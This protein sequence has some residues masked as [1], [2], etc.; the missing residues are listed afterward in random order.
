MVPQGS[1]GSLSR[2][3]N[4]LQV[5]LC[6]KNKGNMSELVTTETKLAVES[7][8]SLQHS[9]VCPASFKT[10]SQLMVPGINN[11]AQDL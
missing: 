1:P 6:L 8:N 2:L 5:C 3:P 7:S 4:E 11:F 10:W 9:T